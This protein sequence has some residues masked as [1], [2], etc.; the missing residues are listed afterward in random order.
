MLATIPSATLLGID[1]HAVTVEVHVSSGIPGLTIVGQPDA[2]CREARD[3]VRA[4][5]LS[6]GAEWPLR[7][8][9][10]NLAPTGLRKIGAGLDLALAVGV[11]AAAGQVPSTALDD[12]AFLGELGL[13]GSIRPVAGML[14]L[15]EAVRADRVVL[16]RAS[17]AEA[18]LVDRHQLL[19][20]ACLDEVLDALR[21]EAGWP[22]PPPPG[23]PAPEPAVPELADVRGQPVACRA[24]E[25]AAA[26]GHHLLMVGPPGAGKTMLASRLPGLLPPLEASEAM[27][28]TRVHS[29]AGEALPP[30]GLVTNPPFRAPHHSCT[31]VALAGGG[32]AA[33]RPGEISLA[34]G[35]VLFLDELGEFGAV[36]IDMLRQP[37]EAGCIRVSR[38]RGTVSFPA[39]VLLV[40]ATNPCPCGAPTGPGS[41]RCSDAARARY[42]R[43]ISGPV[44]DR[45]DLRLGVPRLDSRALFD[46]PGGPPTAEVRQRVRAARDLAWSR[47]VRANADLAGSNLDEA[48]P[49]TGASAT[50]LRGEVDRGRLSARGLQ[51]VRRVART[52]ADLDGSAAVDEGHLHEA[53]LLRAPVVET[54]WAVAS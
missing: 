9:T 36:V 42:A 51:R 41:C 24:L 19:P 6:V 15:I 7:R 27:E 32:S 28:V 10:V 20:V 53:L 37:L 23:P 13:D 2:A 18:R 31:A 21:G 44:L 50:V 14:P 12:L 29:A 26:G 38:A 33:L 45:F 49:L 48:V 43:R 39:R 30:G 22:P 47:G 5:L 40:A 35:G 4:A 16:P 3:R 52:L 11:M 17:M 8:I 1:G 34:H 54:G 25:V 46:S